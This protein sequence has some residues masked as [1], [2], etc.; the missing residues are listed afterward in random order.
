MG[1]LLASAKSTLKKSSQ[2]PEPFKTRQTQKGKNAKVASV[3]PP[4]KIGQAVDEFCELR[5]DIKFKEGELTVLKDVV[6]NF[7]QDEFTRR[8]VTGIPGGFHVQGIKR[9]LTY[10]VQDASA[11]FSAE[12]Y[13]LFEERWGEE[14]AKELLVEDLG[15]IRFNADVLKANKDLVVKALQALPANVLEN[16]F[17]PALMKSTDG[18]LEKAKRYAKSPKELREMME[19]LK[20]K[21][22][23]R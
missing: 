10:V 16:L 11:G 20:I 2:K 5:D 8:T 19:Q 1:K 21:N 3:L 17:L 14:A 23:V 12:E 15:S 6:M 9:S 7:A 13:V 18:A 22:Y 4:P